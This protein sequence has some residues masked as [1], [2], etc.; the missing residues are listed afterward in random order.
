[1]NAPRGPDGLD[2]LVED[3]ARIERR[4]AERY[5]HAARRFFDVPEPATPVAASLRVRLAMVRHAR[6]AR[7]EAGRERR[8]AGIRDAAER[9]AARAARIDERI[10]ELLER[11]AML[12]RR[13][14]VYLAYARREAYER[15]GRPLEDDVLNAHH[16]RAH[17]ALYTGP[18]DLDQAERLV[19]R[20]VAAVR[21]RFPEVTP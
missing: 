10:G 1:M 4:T 13:L 9:A 15:D 8:L 19:Q 16:E 17:A 6:G 14:D 12:R 2:R 5:D 11:R 18:M 21:R 7:E 20:F 3:L